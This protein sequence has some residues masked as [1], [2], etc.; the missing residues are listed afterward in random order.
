MYMRKNITAGSWPLIRCTD[1]YKSRMSAS[2]SQRGIARSKLDA[3][4]MN[5]SQHMPKRAALRGLD[6]KDRCLVVKSMAV[7]K[8]ASVSESHAMS[9]FSSASHKP[10]HCGLLNGIESMISGVDIAIALLSS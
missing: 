7:Q 5:S 10:L 4:E 1:R 2:T 8:M 9:G 6:L 3:F